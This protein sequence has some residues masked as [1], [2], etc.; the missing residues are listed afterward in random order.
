MK[1]YYQKRRMVGKRAVGVT[2]ENEKEKI[3]TAVIFSALRSN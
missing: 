3:Q 1:R 2:K